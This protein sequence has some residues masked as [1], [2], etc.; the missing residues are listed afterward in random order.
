MMACAS[1]NTQGTPTTPVPL[2]HYQ[3]NIPT[4][5]FSAMTLN[6]TSLVPNVKLDVKQYPVFHGENSQWPKFKRGVLSIASTHG[7]DD[8]FDQNTIVPLYSDPNYDK[9]Q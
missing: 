8:I 5:P 9:Y 3:S 2:T 7:L 4:T 6:T 1:Q